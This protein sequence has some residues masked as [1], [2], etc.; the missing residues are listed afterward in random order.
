VINF[1][2]KIRRKVHE[3]Y[4]QDAVLIISYRD[5][6]KPQNPA[7]EMKLRAGLRNF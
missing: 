7:Q 4:L 2:K 5:K 1:F 6:E 3:N